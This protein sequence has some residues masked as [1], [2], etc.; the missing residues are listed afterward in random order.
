VQKD[1]R[2][3]LTHGI[4]ETLDKIVVFRATHPLVPPTDV[5]RVAEALFIVGAN[6]E[7][8]R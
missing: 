4:D 8:N 7:E 5:K 2:P 3:S 6:I 1:V